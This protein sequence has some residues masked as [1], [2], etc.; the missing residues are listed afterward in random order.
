MT[1]TKND[2]QPHSFKRKLGQPGNF[3]SPNYLHKIQ[4]E[5]DTYES[6]LKIDIPPGLYYL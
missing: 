3:C 6:A 5:F 1:E 2:Q 4:L